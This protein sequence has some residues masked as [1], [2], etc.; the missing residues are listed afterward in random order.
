MSTAKQI[1]D[2]LRAAGV[3]FKANDNIAAHLQPGELEA[4]Q[5]EAE[6]HVR[7]MLKALVIDPDHNTADTAKR[8]AKMY[9]REVFA[10]R[11]EPRPDVTDFPNVRQL[12]ELYTVGPITVRST[13]S[14]HLCAVKGCAWIGVIPGERVVGLSKFSRLTEWI[15]ARPQIQEEAVMQLADEIEALIKPQGLGVVIRATHSCMTMRGVREH[16]TTM[17]TSVMRGF[18]RDNAAARDEFLHMIRSQE[19]A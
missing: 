15:M 7:A 18:L 12:D 6:G 19:A 8:V 14:H 13:C 16:D 3:P 4:I 17:T 9:V 5:E 11:Y 10:G 1:A 2:R